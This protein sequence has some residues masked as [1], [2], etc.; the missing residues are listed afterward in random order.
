MQ[1]VL[2]TTYQDLTSEDIWGVLREKNLIDPNMMNPEKANEGRG[3]H[4]A[5][6]QHVS[7]N[8]VIVIDDATGLAWQQA[9]SDDFYSF[10]STGSY[11]NSLNQVSWGGFG[12]WRLPTLEEALSLMEHETKNDDLCID[13][14]FDSK[15]RWIWTGDMGNRGV[16]SN[17]A[18]DLPWA[19]SFTKGGQYSAMNPENELSIRAVRTVLS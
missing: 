14:M 17:K 12:D 2:R 19:V 13:P 8:G 7:S 18:F 15:Q 11:V 1:I 4:H 6:R 10:Y 5:Y 3:I 16:G 9:G